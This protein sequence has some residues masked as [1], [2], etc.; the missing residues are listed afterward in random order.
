MTVEEAVVFFANQPQDRRA[1]CRR[2]WTWAWGMSTLGQ[3]ATDPLRRRG[4][5][6]Q[7]GQRAGTAA[8]R[9]GPCISWTSPPPACTSADVHR[10]IEVL[11]KLVDAGNTVVVI[12]HNLDVIKCADY[13][14]DLGPEGGGAGGLDRRRGYAGAGGRGAGQLYPASTSSPCWKRT[15]TPREG[16]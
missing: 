15:R 1:S 7:A 3:S 9:A 2:C 14:I 8:A 16:K 11:Q 6:R 4:A 13:I 5:A 12:E 10:L